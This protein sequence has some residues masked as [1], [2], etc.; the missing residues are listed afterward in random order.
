MTKIILVIINVD[1]YDLFCVSKQLAIE[2]LCPC[3]VE[4]EARCR[5]WI[6]SHRLNA[7]LQMA[8]GSCELPILLELR[9]CGNSRDIKPVTFVGK[10]NFLFFFF[11]SG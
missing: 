5:E 7:F 3:G 9:Y 2:K 4:V 1:F 10:S 6:E 11:L 8:K